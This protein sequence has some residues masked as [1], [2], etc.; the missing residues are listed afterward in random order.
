[1]GASRARKALTRTPGSIILT[2]QLMPTSLALA[3]RIWAVSC[4]QRTEASAQTS[5]LIPS[6]YLP[7]ALAASTAFLAASR[8][9][10]YHLPTS[11]GGRVQGAIVGLIGPVAM[12]RPAVAILMAASRSKAQ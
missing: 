3:D 5:V 4:R 7:D 1:M 9:R 2:S 10:R 8:S 11:S 6:G 12:P